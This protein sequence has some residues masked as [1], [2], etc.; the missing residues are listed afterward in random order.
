MNGTVYGVVVVPLIMGLVQAA[1]Q[2]GLP[3]R[4]AAALAVALG[5]IGGVALQFAAAGQAHPNW[6]QGVI[7]GIGLGLSAAGLYS[8]TNALVTNRGEGSEQAK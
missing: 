8:G 5:L 4:W 1:K 6:V 3:N 7:V 2:V